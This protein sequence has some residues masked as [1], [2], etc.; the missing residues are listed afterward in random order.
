MT[1]APFNLILTIGLTLAGCNR[2]DA[3]N[4]VAPDGGKAVVVVPNPKDA[5]KDDAPKIDPAT[6]AEEDAKAE[7]WIPPAERE[8]LFLDFAMEDQDGEPF[9]L[10]SIRG[11]PTV[12]TF[13]FTRCPNPN[14]C[15]LQGAKMAALQKTLAAAG[16]AEKVNILI[17]SFDPEYD[18]PPRLKK[19]AQDAGFDFEQ[20]KVLRPNPREFAEFRYVFQF[21]IGY[22]PDGQLTHRTDLMMI[23]ADGKLARQYAGM[24]K[25]EQAL[26]DVKRLI[27][28]T[29]ASSE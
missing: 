4:V 13:I 7:E 26:E 10:K 1:R 9:E 16:L 5:A 29:E 12:A 19:F 2:N 25:D 27:A 28:E 14:M 8:D 6:K 18:T 15:P 24:W 3:P 22:L 21:R 17:I 20:G 23:D 11:K